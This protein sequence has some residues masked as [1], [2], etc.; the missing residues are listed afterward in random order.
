[1]RRN[2]RGIADIGYR[3]GGT[4]IYD[5]VSGGNDFKSTLL[6]EWCGHY[7]LADQQIGIAAGKQ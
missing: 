1:M 6:H 3:G 4:A 2:G 5:Q 7:V